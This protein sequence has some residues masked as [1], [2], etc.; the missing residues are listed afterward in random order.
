[1]FKKKEVK[2]QV[3]AINV[4]RIKQIQPHIF[5]RRATCKL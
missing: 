5:N 1:M 3:Q 4:L 2:I